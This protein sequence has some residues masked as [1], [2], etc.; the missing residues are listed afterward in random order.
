MSQTEQIQ[1]F[2]NIAA[3]PG[4][5]AQLREILTSLV[6]HTKAEPGCLAY[7]LHE[8]IKTP[9]AFYFYEVY[10]DEA[11]VDAH[12]QSPYFAEAFAKAG[13][14]LSGKPSIILTKFVAGH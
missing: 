6:P 2:A 9:G 10:K 11:A 14:L 7:V 13:P 8:D 1:I 4:K 12:R 5:E 3:L